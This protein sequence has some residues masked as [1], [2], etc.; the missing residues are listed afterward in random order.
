[1]THKSYLLWIAACQSSIKVDAS[2]RLL[3]AAA[4]S[5]GEL[6]SPYIYFRI[7]LIPRL[8]DPAS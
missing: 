1:M 3:F 4:S 7:N 2:T 5:D 6:E 8:G